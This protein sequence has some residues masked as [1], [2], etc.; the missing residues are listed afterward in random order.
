VAR[1]LATDPAHRPPSAKRVEESL[2]ATARLGAPPLR[3]GAALR[4]R[5]AS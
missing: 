3:P 5:R 2:R 4:G 1:L